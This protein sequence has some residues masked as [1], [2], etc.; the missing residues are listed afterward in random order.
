MSESK[1]YA[2]LLIIAASDSIGGAGIQADI[3]TA[4]ARRVY[5]M[6]ALTAATAQNTRAVEAIWPL[7][8]EAVKGQI[9]AVLADVMPDAV[10]LG[11]LYNSEIVKCVAKEI[12]GKGMTHVVCDPVAV[13]SCGDSLSADSREMAQAMQSDLFPLCELVTPNIPEAEVFLQ[14][15]VV[16]P[17]ADAKVLLDEWGCGAVLLKGGHGQSVECSDI[18]VSRETCVKFSHPRISTRN[19]H[20][21]GCT[22]SS[23]I[24]CGLAKGLELKKAVEEGIGFVVKALR[25]GAP[26]ALGGGTGPLCFWPGKDI[27]A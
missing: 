17:E 10:K 9:D 11:M 12:R 6:T 22:L 24:A 21:T 7:P 16:D 19:S 2:T 23:A 8:V 14:R 4:T 5:A 15:K 20:G 18:L 13:A 26:Y 25:S 27:E 1:K 3:K